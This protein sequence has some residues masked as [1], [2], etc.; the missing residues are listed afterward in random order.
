MLDVSAIALMLPMLL[1]LALVVAGGIRVTSGGPV[2]FRQER[3][4]YR[5]RKFVCFKFRTMANGSNSESHSKH[6]QVLMQSN[7]PMTKMDSQGDVRISRLGK[8]LRASGLD[9]L[10]QLLNVL[11]GEMSLVGPRPCLPYE[12]E[13]YEPWQRERFEAMP[14][15]TGLWQVSGKNRTSFTQM[16]Q[17]DIRYAK[18]KSLSLDLKIM[19][20]TPSVLLVQL[21]DLCR[22]GRARQVRN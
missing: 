13:K 18:M 4:G 16:V 14:G 22:N 15:L 3:V 10:P 7:A 1:P 20:R 2:L 8:L 9:E 5:G 12:E 19:A 6:L 11:R 17:L 21:L